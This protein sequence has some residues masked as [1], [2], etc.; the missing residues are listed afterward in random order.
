MYIPSAYV[1]RQN[2]HFPSAY[3]WELIQYYTKSS[4]VKSDFVYINKKGS[5]IFLK[6]S[7]G[8]ESNPR[9]SGYE[10]EA[11]SLSYLDLDEK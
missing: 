4:E 2:V 8:R 9:P 10:A 1:A 11:L 5:F 6:E 3:I 7:P